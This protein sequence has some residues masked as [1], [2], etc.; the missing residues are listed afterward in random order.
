[1][2]SSKE[3]PASF[4]TFLHSLN[5]ESRATYERH[6]K[7]FLKFESEHSRLSLSDVVDAFFEDLH[8]NQQLKTSTIWTTQSPIKVC[9][10]S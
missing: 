10:L 9:Y 8:E 1:M 4:E 6:V 2:S 5:S 7:S 3:W